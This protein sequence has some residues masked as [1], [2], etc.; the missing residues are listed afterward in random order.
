[1]EQFD[2]QNPVDPTDLIARVVEQEADAISIELRQEAVSRFTAALQADWID[3]LKQAT[4]LYRETEFLLRWTS[5]EI[6]HPAMILGTV[7]CLLQDSIGKWHLI[8][9]KTGAVPTDQNGL[10]QKFGVQMTLFALAI[11]Q[12][13]GTL[14]ASIRIVQLAAEPQVHPFALSSALI[15]AKRHQINQAINWLR[16]NALPPE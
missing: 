8:D 13:T 6:A 14:P 5:D 12:L 1:M 10:V 16:S 9:Y 15:D 3:E 7:D 2:P 4:Q 11:E